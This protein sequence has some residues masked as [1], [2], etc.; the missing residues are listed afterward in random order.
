LSCRNPSSSL[1]NIQ[2]SQ[3]GD[4]TEGPTETGPLLLATAAM[5]YI[6]PF[7]SEAGT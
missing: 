6:R 1:A 7:A 2:Q 5:R 3:G 4:Q